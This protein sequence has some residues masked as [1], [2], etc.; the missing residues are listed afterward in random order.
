MKKTDDTRLLVLS[1]CGVWCVYVLCKGVRK[2]CFFTVCN[3]HMKKTDDTMLLVL[4]T[5]VIIRIC[6]AKA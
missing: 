1:T 4:S 6:A 3:R 5:C 2:A